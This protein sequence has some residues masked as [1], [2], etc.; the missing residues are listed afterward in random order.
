MKD[1]LVQMTYEIDLQPGEQLRLAETLVA[2]IGPGRWRVTVRPVR[3]RSARTHAAFL[4]GYAAEDEG[5][6]DDYPTR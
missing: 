4:N 5:L 6:Y 3:R 2:G 1:E